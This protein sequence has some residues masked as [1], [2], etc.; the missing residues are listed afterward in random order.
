MPD[1]QAQTALD[2]PVRFSEQV[3]EHLRR[4]INEGYFQ[5]GD[6]MPSEANLC[7]RFGVSRTVVREALAS[8][9]YEGLL[10][11]EQGRGMIVMRPEQ[12]VTFRI[13]PMLDNA[14]DEYAYIY[15]MRAV[16]EIEAAAWAAMR[17]T[18]EDIKD[19][20]YFHAQLS[21]A[22]RTKKD[23]AEAHRGFNLSLFRAA[24]NKYLFDYMIFLVGHL[25][26]RMHEDRE[27]IDSRPGVA[28]IV[29]QEHKAILHAI[30]ARDP[31]AARRATLDHLHQAA[32]RKGLTSSVYFNRMDWMSDGGPR[33]AT[34]DAGKSKKNTNA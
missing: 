17:R 30:I 7:E 2:K 31:G 12:R 28:E 10:V 20:R 5:A 13:D 9:K 24:K 14:D 18:E 29:E 33:P 27:R 3:A 4:E 15:D 25:N 23:G 32:R 19:L 34:C 26:R 22:V 11:A 1:K 8:L 16:L 21:E 6:T